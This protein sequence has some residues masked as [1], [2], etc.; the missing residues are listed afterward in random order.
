MRTATAE[1][2]DAARAATTGDPVALAALAKVLAEVDAPP[3]APSPPTAARLLVDRKTAY[4]AAICQALADAVRRADGTVELPEPAAF[5]LT[6]ANAAHAR[7]VVAGYE[8]RTAK[9]GRRP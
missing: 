9:R 8:E 2:L 6:E 4:R 7:E 5:G 3:A 1:L